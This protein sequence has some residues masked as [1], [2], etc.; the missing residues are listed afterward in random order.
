VSSPAGRDATCREKFARRLPFLIYALAPSEK[1]G[2]QAPGEGFF[3]CFAG[4]TKGDDQLCKQK[5]Q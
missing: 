1:G 2:A 5:A 4:P 3:S